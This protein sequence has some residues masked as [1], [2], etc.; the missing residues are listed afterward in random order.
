MSN[1]ILSLEVRFPD[2]SDV[3]A[4]LFLGLT[5]TSRRYGIYLPSG[6]LDGAPKKRIC[7]S[8]ICK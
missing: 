3:T 4:N 5:G 6:L 2:L 1:H 8:V 7:T